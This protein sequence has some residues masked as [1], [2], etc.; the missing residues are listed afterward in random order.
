MCVHSER[1]NVAVYEMAVQ[2]D[3]Y[4]KR[5]MSPVFASNLIPW[6]SNID[7]ALDLVILCYNVQP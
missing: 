5:L 2:T 1:W 7:A 4:M 3:S 6:H